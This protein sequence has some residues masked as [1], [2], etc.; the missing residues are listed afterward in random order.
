MIQKVFCPYSKPYPPNKPRKKLIKSITVKEINLGNYNSVDLTEELRHVD[1][2]YCEGEKDYDDCINITIF[3]QKQTE[4]D[5]PTYDTQ[6]KE[7]QRKYTEYKR[8][9]KEW[10]ELKIKR[11]KKNKNF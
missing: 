5:N 10:K 2:I 1:T 4:I 11:D 7:Y 9:L 8:E 6:L 3:F